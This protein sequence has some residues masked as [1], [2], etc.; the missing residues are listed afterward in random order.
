MLSK[1]KYSEASEQNKVPILEVLS[2]AFNDC[3]SV[4][5]VGSGSGQHAVFF[6]K[7]LKHL[8]WQ[9]SD[10]AENLNSIQA[11]MDEESL[12]NIFPPIELDVRQHPWQVEKFDA[13]YSANTFHIM[14]WEMIEDFFQGA[15]AFLKSQGKLLVYGPFSYHGKHTSPSNQQ[16]DNHLKQRDPLSGVRDFVEL[17]KLAQ[18]QG[19]M[20]IEDFAMPANNRCLLWQN[21][22]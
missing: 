6:A 8:N 17:D 3:N 16:F 18:A 12:E 2:D 13:I 14:S 7:H 21:I 9:P 5:E 4:L 15:G 20:F 10:L 19:L 22:K 1:R 11:W